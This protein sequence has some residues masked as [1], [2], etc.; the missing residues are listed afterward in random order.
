[1]ASTPTLHPETADAPAPSPEPASPRS[2]RAVEWVVDVASHRVVRR[3]RATASDQ[4]KQ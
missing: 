2:P 3:D 4:H 1:M